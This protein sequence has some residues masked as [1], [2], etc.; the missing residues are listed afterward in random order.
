MKNGLPSQRP[1]WRPASVLA[2]NL[3]LA[4]PLA[5]TAAPWSAASQ[6]TLDRKITLRA[7]A[8]T[9]ESV[10]DRLEQQLDVRHPR[11][12][13]AGAWHHY[14]RHHRCYR[15]LQPK[16]TGGQHAGVQ[17][18]GLHGAGSTAHGQ[19]YGPGYLSEGER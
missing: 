9:I 2:L 1:L 5:S 17:Q 12:N 6:I 14:R 10:L 15:R 13:G 19:H 7:E 4:A 3:L 18:R 11:R 8:Q 16:R